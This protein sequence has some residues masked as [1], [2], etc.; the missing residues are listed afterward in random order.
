MRII[1]ILPML[2]VL[3][4]GSVAHAGHG[5]DGFIGERDGHTHDNNHPATEA[6]DDQLSLTHP[7]DI[8]SESAKKDIPP[9]I[10]SASWLAL[11]PFLLLVM[12]GLVRWWIAVGRQRKH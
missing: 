10:L 5:F 12:V 1:Q 8:G 11:S 2:L 3:L 9:S 7:S 6:V 4:H